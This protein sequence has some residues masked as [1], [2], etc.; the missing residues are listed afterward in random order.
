VPKGVKVRVLLDA[1]NSPNKSKTL[2]SGCIRPPISLINITCSKRGSM[3]NINEGLKS[4]LLFLSKL[5]WKKAIL[6]IVVSVLVISTWIIL[7]FGDQIADFIKGY[8]IIDHTDKT[9]D[10]IPIGPSIVVKPFSKSTIDV[11]NNTVNNFDLI[12]GISVVAIDFQK[13]S[14]TEVYAYSNDPN[15]QKDFSK[16]EIFG[17]EHPFFTE[18]QAQN[19]RFI[20]MLNGEV[21]C[22]PYIDTILSIEMPDSTKYVKAIC[23]TGIPPYFGKFIGVVGLYLKREPTQ[24]EV[25]QLRIVV[26]NLST[27]I[28]E[29][30]FKN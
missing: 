2:L 17:V 7:Q 20:K 8:K 11:L 3:P 18:N 24:A 15:L 22:G 14:R 16:S 1:P 25:D 6:Q 13:N 28:A 4:L 29:K 5:T 19:T 30:E 23:S 27:M 26:K 10:R 12:A 9:I 21:V